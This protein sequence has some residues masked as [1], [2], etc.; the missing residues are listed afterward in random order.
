MSIRFS[1]GNNSLWLFSL[2]LLSVGWEPKEEEEEEERRGKGKYLDPGGCSAP[3]IKR[4]GNAA[5]WTRKLQTRKITIFFFFFYLI[6]F[7]G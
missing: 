4:R 1:F 3:L 6:F 5:Q 2:S 7:W